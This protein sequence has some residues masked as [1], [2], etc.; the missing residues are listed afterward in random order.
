VTGA[1]AILDLAWPQ[2]TEDSGERCVLQWPARFLVRSVWRR[3]PALTLRRSWPSPR[4]SSADS[5]STSRIDTGCSNGVATKAVK[6]AA[7]RWDL[8]VFADADPDTGDILGSLKQ[9]TAL[10]PDVAARLA[11]QLLPERHAD[12]LQALT[13]SIATGF[14]P[15]FE[16]LLRGDQRAWRAAALGLQR[17]VLSDIGQLR[18]RVSAVDTRLAWAIDLL[19]TPQPVLERFETLAKKQDDRSI[20]PSDFQFKRRATKYLPRHDVEAKVAA[21]LAAPEPVR[22]LRLT[23][24]AGMGKSRLALEIC[25]RCHAEHWLAGFHADATR[26]PEAWE[27]LRDTLVVIDYAAS[28]SIGGQPVFRWIESLQRRLERTERSS[29]AKVRVILIDRAAQG[30]LWTDWK[31]S[32]E[33]DVLDQRKLD[34]DLQPQRDEFD[35]IVQRELE[36]R[37]RRRPTHAERQAIGAVA[38]RLKEQFRPLFGLLTAAAIAEAPTGS[39]AHWSPELLIA[40]ILKSELAKWKRSGVTDAHLELLYEAT[41]TQGAC[42]T[43]P[44]FRHKLEALT[45]GEL[46]AVSALSESGPELGPVV[47]DLL[48]EFFVLMRLRGDA[49]LGQQQPSVVARTADTMLQHA[50][51]GTGELPFLPRLL[52]DYLEWEPAEGENPAR[53]IEQLILTA[54]EEGKRSQ[55]LF[56]GCLVSAQ[57]PG[58]TRDWPAWLAQVPSR[59]RHV[60]VMAAALGLRRAAASTRDPSAC[61]SIVRQL[62]AL[63]VMAEHDSVT[64]TELAW[65]TVYSAAV[66][67]SDDARRAAV[68]RVAALYTEGGDT[69]EL[70]AILAQAFLVGSM[71]EPDVERRRGFLRQ[72]ERLHDGFE[73]DSDVRGL[74]V[75]ALSAAL[76][77]EQEHAERVSIIQR[78]E[79]LYATHHDDREIGKLLA[80]ALALACVSAG[81]ERKTY[82]ERLETLHRSRPEP[83]IREYL[84]QT[85]A[86]VARTQGR[87]DERRALA[88]RIAEIQERAPS[89]ATA[90][91]LAAALVAAA[92][93]APTS[94]DRRRIIREI[95]DLHKRQPE[96]GV[97]QALAESV[98]ST[99]GRE[100][101]GRRRRAATDH[102]ARLY[103]EHGREPDIGKALAR[104][105]LDAARVESDVT[106]CRKLIARLDALSADQPGE[107]LVTAALVHAFCSA[108]RLERDKAQRHKARGRL[109]ALV[110]GVRDVNGSQ[111]GERPLRAALARALSM[112][113]RVAEH[114]V[115][116]ASFLTRLDELHQ[117][118]PDDEIVRL[119]LAIALT[120]Q[121]Y[122]RLGAVDAGEMLDEAERRYTTSHDERGGDT[123]LGFM[124]AGL[125]EVE[126]LS[127]SSTP[128]EYQTRL[129]ALRASSSS[130]RM[131]HTFGTGMFAAAMGHAQRVDE[132]L[133]QVTA[134]AT[135]K[136]G[137]DQGRKAVSTFKDLLQKLME[138][139]KQT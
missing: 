43:Q 100:T 78:V 60:A 120:R 10:D 134:M 12:V 53:H 24:S 20:K 15:T 94:D 103:E 86:H 41:L 67:A 135:A 64:R 1:S 28:R 66:P 29:S 126:A 35:S 21:W 13:D 83:A 30:P 17:L 58:A 49:T 91:H 22:F 23:G 33:S 72:L 14:A 62:E 105:L 87:F 63:H 61:A 52:E 113:E 65:A 85:L 76:L 51:R 130:L 57:R 6:R 77:R 34:I 116:K 39:T 123:I 38:D 132:V 118:A 90:E 55:T 32:E 56:H 93:L 89:A 109:R 68:E 114:D 18:D 45:P 121:E 107:P 54:L 104:G 26:W 136:L 4:R 3:K 139:R 84:T 37:L 2:V 27:P 48:G 131:A 98:A 11:R 138:S 42:R 73:R 133:E 127:E 44:E 81:A 16:V 117:S 137:V 70:R 88:D 31:N 108:L 7:D 124:M 95:D 47:P 82:V 115:E 122:K 101:D 19:R 69:P 46:A 97:R 96:P 74:L 92:H 5:A 59:T 9:P 25:D 128:P 75:M 111:G 102:I 106:A 99:V 79:G 80:F 40:S 112:L 50:L 110:D 119:I 8:R 125:T 129:H 71:N 36:R